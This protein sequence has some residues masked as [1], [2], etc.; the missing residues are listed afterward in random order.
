MLKNILKNILKHVRLPL[1]GGKF[2]LLIL[3]IALLVSIVVTLLCSQDDRVTI[4][5][6]YAGP[7]DTTNG[8][9]RM[10]LTQAL[11]EKGYRVLMLDAH[12]DQAMQIQQLSVMAD[13]GCSALIIEPVMASAR[14]ELLAAVEQVG[15][16]AV[17]LGGDPS[18]WLPQDHKRVMCTDERVA[19]AGDALAQMVLGL[20]NSGDVNGDG[21]VSCLLLTGPQDHLADQAR[22]QA[23]LQALEQSGVEFMFLQQQPGALHQS[24]CG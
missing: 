19:F 2:W 9:Y 8:H 21:V 14:E 6:C 13:R 18:Y 23:C 7:T 12:Q 4:G 24:G 5:L 10:A 11:E 20:P 3:A 1:Q 16:P 15:L 17:L 22:V